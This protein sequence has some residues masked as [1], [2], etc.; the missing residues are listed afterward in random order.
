MTRDP[1]RDQPVLTAG[2]KLSEAAGAIIL[3]HGRGGS[4]EDILQLRNELDYPELAYV[5]PQAAENTWYPYSFLAPIEQNE[6]WLT[7]ALNKLKN[8]VGNITREGIPQDKIV[9]AGFSQGACLASEFVA[10]NA[11]NCGG[12]IAF[13]GGLIGPPGTDFHNTGSLSGT[14]VFLGAGD[15]DAH[16]LLRCYPGMPHTISRQELEEARRLLD[17]TFSPDSQDR[18]DF[19]L[20]RGSAPIAA[21]EKR[22]S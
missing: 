11:A 16:V 7:S 18:R 10:R 21:L 3:V 1:H 19:R 15:P 8:T 9:I 6:P 12:L 13:T 2:R 5:A 14:P 20:S 22:V 4:A 17:R